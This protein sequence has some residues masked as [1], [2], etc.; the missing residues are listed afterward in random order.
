MAVK[1]VLLWPHP[2]PCVQTTGEKIT[3]NK[4]RRLK[5]ETSFVLRRGGSNG[6][7]LIMSPDRSID[8][9]PVYM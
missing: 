1:F 9:S 6:E 4:I 5:V 7:A 8:A 2:V 3:D